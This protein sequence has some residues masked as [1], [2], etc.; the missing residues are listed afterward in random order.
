[1]SRY[2]FNDG[3]EKFLSMGLV[4]SN[5]Q[6][7]GRAR[8]SLRNIGRVLHALKESGTI[9]SDNPLRMVPN[10]IQ[11]F[12]DEGRSGGVSESTVCRDLSYLNDYLHSHHND[13]V[14][15][16]ISGIRARDLEEKRAASQTALRGYSSGIPRIP[17]IRLVRAYAFVMLAIV[18]DMHP[19]MLRKAELR[20]AHA[21]GSV[22]NSRISFVDRR[23][24]K[25]TSA[26]ISAGSRSSADTSGTPCS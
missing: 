21:N 8:N 1:M 2:P 3:I 11:R 19:E 12:V 4:D 7:I 17:E 9:Q 10:D 22:N 25:R 16:Y 14:E 26:S 24:W 6:S 18:F 20:S 5:E 15:E 13:A 23:D